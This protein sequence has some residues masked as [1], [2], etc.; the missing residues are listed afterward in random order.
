[1][2]DGNCSKRALLSSVCLRKVASTTNPLRAN[3]AAGRR[4]FAS[5][6]VPHLR[7]AVVQVFGVPGTPTETPLV[8]SSGVK[9]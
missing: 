5:D 4:V 7:S 1:M 9:L 8:T 2:V 3:R 6:C